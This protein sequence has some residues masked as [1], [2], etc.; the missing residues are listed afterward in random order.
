MNTKALAFLSRVSGDSLGKH[1][2]KILP[3]LMTSLGQHLGTDDEQ[4]VRE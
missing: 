3:A 4:Q 1:L 2:H